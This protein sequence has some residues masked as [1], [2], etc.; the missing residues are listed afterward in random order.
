[1]EQ[2]LIVILG[3]N[4]RVIISDIRNVIRKGWFYIT[5]FAVMVC[6]WLDLG[7]DSYWVLH[8]GGMDPM[9]LLEKSLSGP[10]SALSLPLLASL[11]CAAHAMQELLTGAARMSIFRSGYRNYILAKLLTVLL[12]AALAQIAGIILFSLLLVVASPSTSNT[13]FP[14]DITLARI[15][16]TIVFASIGG[17]AAL[18][19]KDTVSAYAVPTALSFALSMLVSRFFVEAK[20]QYLDPRTWLTGDKSSIL[21]L[22]V[23]LVFTSTLYVLVLRKE[24]NNY[25]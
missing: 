24:I 11:P 14:I 3:I 7:T 15:L 25:V 10:G 13:P 2:L 5:I 8:G 21:L 4:M 18:L 6:L 19:S 9:L 23:L 16:S 12:M 1:M 17:T 20:Y 22:S